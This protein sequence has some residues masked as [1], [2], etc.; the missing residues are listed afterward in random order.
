M[1]I[2]KLFSGHRQFVAEDVD[3]LA[4]FASEMHIP[5]Q[6]LIEKDLVR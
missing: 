1:G 2:L 6:S 5:D 4:M 3:V